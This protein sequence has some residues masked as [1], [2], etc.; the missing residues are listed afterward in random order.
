MTDLQRRIDELGPWFHNLHL[1]DG[2]GGVVMTRPDSPF[3]DFPKFKWD[4]LAPHLPSDLTG[5]RILDVGCNAG[6]YTIELARRGGHVVGLDLND[7]YLRQARFAVELCGVADR[8]TFHNRQVYD[9]A[10]TDWRF[11]L[12]LFMGVFYHLRYP[13]LGLDAV[14][15]T[16]NDGGTLVF[17]T[18]TLP[19]DAEPVTTKDADF[20]DRDRLRA[21]GWPKMAFFEH[22]FT[23]DPTNW[24]AAD[25]NC[26]EA[27]LRSCGLRVTGRPMHE[28]YLAT[29]DPTLYTGVPH[30]REAEFRAAI[31]LD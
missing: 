23:G 7:H 20:N 8:V 26:C 4:A 31:G 17:Q 12:I 24:W 22:G 9:L 1:P 5:R 30:L 6:F 25:P 13:L 28:T 10:R 21:E 15:S 14:R 19:S 29:P 16:L 18:L 11:D 2:H 27:L 3:G